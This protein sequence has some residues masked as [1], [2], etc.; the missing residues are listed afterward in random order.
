M[1]NETVSVIIPTYNRAA[2]L[3]RAVRSA[4]AAITPGDEII[5]VDDGSTD[6]TAAAIAPF[7]DVVR[8]V[9]ILHS[10]AAASRNRGVREARCPLVAFL[11]S[12][13][14]WFTDK[15]TLQRAV[16]RALPDALFCFSDFVHRD[17]AGVDHPHYLINWHQDSRGWEEILGPGRPF[18]SFGELPSGRADFSVHVGNLYAAAL[19]A[20]YVFTT[21]LLVRR[22]LAGE[23]LYFPEDVYFLED[24]ECFACLARKGTAAYLD[25]DTAWNHS[26]T[27]PRLTDG[28]TLY[29]ATARVTLLERVWGR[30][31]DFLAAH[32]HAFQE[33]MAKH[34][35]YRARGLLNAGRAKEAREAL[36][37]AG[38][39]PLSH[40]VLACLPGTLVR[41][42]VRLGKRVRRGGGEAVA[43]AVEN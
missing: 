42:M 40:R 12:D 28:D 14:E 7:Q 15:L 1:Q 39:G 23:T 3:P 32:G 29:F 35:V 25:C 18:S 24:Q 34:Q 26:H 41:E 21:T 38:G 5:I 43:A 27:G 22:A 30:D 11:D 36:R 20:D 10:G 33:V 17:R 4:L 31:A 2:L 19:R 13:D 16:L 8:Y 9:R 6:Q 37:R